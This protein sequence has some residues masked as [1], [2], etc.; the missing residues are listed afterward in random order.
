MKAGVVAQAA[1]VAPAGGV[2][3]SAGQPSEATV[4]KHDSRPRPSSSNGGMT[5]AKVRL[6]YYE[7][8]E[9]T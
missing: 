9:E 1:V 8:M 2:A 7:K 3:P 4:L 6:R 5:A